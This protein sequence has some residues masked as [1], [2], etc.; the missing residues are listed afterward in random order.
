MY[1]LV[2]ALVISRRIHHDFP[3]EGPFPVNRIIFHHD[4][5]SRAPNA[6]RYH[7][8]RNR[9]R[10]GASSVAVPNTPSPNDQVHHTAHTRCPH[11]L[12]AAPPRPR[13]G[14]GS[15]SRA[16]DLPPASRSSPGPP[17]RR[18]K[19][20]YPVLAGRHRSVVGTEKTGQIRDAWSLLPWSSSPWRK[21]RG[22]PPTGRNGRGC[23]GAGDT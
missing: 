15:G 20:M 19:E 8:T 10:D 2:Y 14:S 22:H 1:A 11:P 3:M 16:G 13:P 12:P 6:H 7:H 23:P 9:R 18:G 17:R 21:D 5:D 4:G